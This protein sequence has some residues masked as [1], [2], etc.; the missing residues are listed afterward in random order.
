M[1]QTK[2][3]EKIKTLV[4]CSVTFLKNL[5]VFYIFLYNNAVP[6][7]PQMTIWCMRISCCVPKP[8]N[9]HSDYVTR[10]AFPPQQWLHE[11]D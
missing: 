7:R 1:F 2:I 8:T 4:I 5:F 3:L 11:C 6:D 9:P 10:I